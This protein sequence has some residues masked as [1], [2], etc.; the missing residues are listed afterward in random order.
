MFMNNFNHWLLPVKNRISGLLSGRE[1][2][3]VALDGRS[4]AGKSTAASLL[5]RELDGE[6]I[7]M[8]DFFLPAEL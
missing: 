5:A 3:V 6:I 2:V 8:D 1:R 7:H 4:A